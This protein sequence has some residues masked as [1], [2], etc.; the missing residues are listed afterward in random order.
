[1]E[2]KQILGGTADGSGAGAGS[3]TDWTKPFWQNSGATGGSGWSGTTPPWQNP[4]GTLKYKSE[5]APT[6]PEGTPP[7]GGHTGD[8][9]TCPH[10]SPIVYPT[11]LGLPF[12]LGN[13]VEDGGAGFALGM[14]MMCSSMANQGK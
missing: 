1:M 7:V 3:G 14:Q 6:P 8:T 2:M 12:S 11:I 5:A 4:D 10:C 13:M 9:S